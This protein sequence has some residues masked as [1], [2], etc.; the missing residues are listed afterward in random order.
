MLLA[1]ADCWVVDLLIET[2]DGRLTTVVPDKLESGNEDGQCQ[3]YEQHDE[4]SANVSD[5]QRAGLTLLLLVVTDT[6]P[7]VLPPLVV[8]H[9]DTPALLHRQ[10]RH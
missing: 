10:D 1:T 6:H 7:R 9:L 2:V 3:T 4:D 5:T 8:Q